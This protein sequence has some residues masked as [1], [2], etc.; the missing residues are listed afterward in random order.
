MNWDPNF[1]KKILWSR[2]DL[3]NQ[4]IF[5]Q[6]ASQTFSIPY[7]WINQKSSQQHPFLLFYGIFLMYLREQV[8]NQGFTCNI[9]THNNFKINFEVSSSLHLFQIPY[10][11][12]DSLESFIKVV[13]FPRC[14]CCSTS[15]R[16]LASFVKNYLNP[17]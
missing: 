10:S 13:T 16:L 12:A 6:K 1:N 9:T 8:N 11:V 3:E 7:Y 17:N 5:L 14:R 2:F 4:Q 15:D